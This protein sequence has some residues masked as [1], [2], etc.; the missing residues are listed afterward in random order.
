MNRPGPRHG[1]VHSEGDAKK[2][3]IALAAT[4][5]RCAAGKGF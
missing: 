3:K 1:Q 4:F 5:L 2:A